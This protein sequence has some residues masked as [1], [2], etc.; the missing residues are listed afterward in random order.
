[1]EMDGSPLA[2]RGDE[3]RRR[4][5]A[6][7][8]AERRAAISHAGRLPHVRLPSRMPAIH[9]QKLSICAKRSYFSSL[10]VLFLLVRLS[11]LVSSHPS[12]H[13]AAS[14]ENGMPR[15]LRT[16]YTN[17][18]LLELEKEFHFNKYLCRPRRI[19]IAAS[20]DLSERQVKVWFQN[21]RMKHKR[22]TQTKS[23]DEKG[24]KCGED[25]DSLDGPLNVLRGK[26]GHGSGDSETSHD[27]DKSVLSPDDTDHSQSSREGDFEP[28]KRTAQ[29]LAHDSA[30]AA[31]VC[32]TAPVAAASSL[33][34]SR[35]SSHDTRSHCAGP[36]CS[37]RHSSDSESH[38]QKPSQHLLRTSLCSSSPPRTSPASLSLSPKTT[39]S[40]SD[41]ASTKTM[42]A[43]SWSG[44]AHR[45]QKVEHASP[46]PGQL[47][48]DLSNGN[49]Y[50]NRFVN[51]SSPLPC[52]TTT[53]CSRTRVSPYMASSAYGASTPQNA[54]RTSPIG[55]QNA[56]CNSGA[57]KSEAPTPYGLLQAS[58]QS[59]LPPSQQQTHH[60]QPHQP[61]Q[62]P[63]HQPAHQPPLQPALQPAQ[64]LA[65]QP[66]QQQLSYAENN[67]YAQ[68]NSAAYYNE[69]YS[70]PD[71]TANYQR[72]SASCYVE[73]H[74][75]HYPSS[76]SGN[77]EAIWNTQTE[78]QWNNEYEYGYDG[79]A[80]G[81]CGNEV[82]TPPSVATNDQGADFRTE[83]WY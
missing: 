58:Q 7:A 30:I 39:P 32:A 19:E 41:L 48:S 49:N 27:L 46:L 79:Y 42:S 3:L 81:W 69:Y 63:V 21:R 44:P 25:E 62:L 59:S 11:R 40:P 75:Q 15:R 34:F 37:P 64:Q 5:T 76:N 22:Q 16:A 12:I 8:S 57:Y 82:A 24:G 31:G 1:M 47:R 33:S 20:L 72:S 54:P 73:Q 9:R 50:Y 29:P 2:G 43:R 55:A 52:A 23:G 61:V 36:L 35:P 13:P 74:Q 80:T 71:Q 53:S 66:A 51:P 45:Q 14:G 78:Q 17:T 38:D 6:T 18:Q 77:Y 28:L 70:P 65:Q 56:F 67:G 4:A 26:G 60:P 68:A 10:T 83:L